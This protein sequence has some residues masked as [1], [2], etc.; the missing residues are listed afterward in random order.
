[1]N[2]DYIKLGPYSEE[3][4]PLNSVTTNQRMYK[5]VKQNGNYELVDI[6]N[7]FWK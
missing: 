6:T 2:F 5:V 7:K 4:G 1:M 3:F